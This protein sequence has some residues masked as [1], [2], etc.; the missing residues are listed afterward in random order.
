MAF[1]IIQAVRE[2]VRRQRGD[3]AWQYQRA[4]CGPSSEGDRKEVL[5]LGFNFQSLSVRGETM[6]GLFGRVWNHGGDR[7]AKDIKEAKGERCLF[8]LL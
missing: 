1:L 5:L 8:L 2:K 7:A 6:A 3:G 4:F